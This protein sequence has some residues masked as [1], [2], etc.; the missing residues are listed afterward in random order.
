[1]PKIL[2]GEARGRKKVRMATKWDK[3]YIHDG[4]KE[5]LKAVKTEDE[6]RRECEVATA[7]DMAIQVSAFGRTLFVI[8]KGF[9]GLGPDRIQKGDVVAVFHGAWTPFILR[10]FGEEFRLVGDCYISGLMDG[11]ALQDGLEERE[12]VIQ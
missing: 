1:M 2:G 8:E 4:H 7:Y 3:H 6:F 12:F 10:P 5:A 9:M 11:E